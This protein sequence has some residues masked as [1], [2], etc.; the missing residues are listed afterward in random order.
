MNETNNKRTTIVGFFIVIGILLLVGGIL[1]I[2]NL[3]STFSRKIQISTI[4]GDVNGLTSGNNI[5]FSGVKIGTVKKI[6]FYGKSQVKVIM[7]IN[8]NATQYIR[9][10]AKVKI[11]TD[12]LIGNKI[13]VIYGGTSTSPEVEDGDNLANE[14]LLSTEDIMNTF[15]QNNLNVLKLTQKL[16]DG[17]G[18]IGRLLS[19]D[20]VYYNI[21][22]T[23]KSLK[24]A[25][26]DAQILVSSL[27]TFGEKLNKEGTLANDLVSDTIVFHS[28]KASILNIKDISDTANVLV[29]NLKEISANPK[30]PIGVL[31]HDEKAGSDLKGSLNNINQGSEK[32]DKNLEALQHSFL[33][34]KYFKKQAQ[35]KVE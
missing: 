35:K 20:S 29:N 24:F 27:A 3:H 14:S 32:L 28:L 6:E 31:L 2:G 21:F 1:V 4:F 9:K 26:S 16:V 5:W 18:T 30:S 33:F 22:E 8:K 25:A 10:D 12:G 15:Q 19:S 23:A 11:S 17:E 7:N 34:R 13:L